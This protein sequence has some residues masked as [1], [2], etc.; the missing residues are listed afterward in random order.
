MWKFTLNGT[1]R[2]SASFDL[3]HHTRIPLV[4]GST[5]SYWTGSDPAITPAH[6]GAYLRATKLV[7]N[8]SKAVPTTARLNAF[9]Q[10]YTPN[11]LAG[12]S[13]SMGDAGTSSSLLNVT[14]IAYLASG[15]VR[16]YRASVVFG[17][18]SGSWSCHW[19]DEANL[20]DGDGHFRCSR[21]PNLSMGWGGTPTVPGGSGGA[22][23][24]IAYTHLPS[25]GYFAYL[26]T[27]RYWFFE[28]SAFWLA[29]GNMDNQDQR[30][31]YADGVMDTSAGYANRGAAW[32]IRNLGEVATFA[33]EAGN[34]RVEHPLRTE[35][36]GY[37]ANNARFYRTKYVDGGTYTEA[38]RSQSYSQVFGTSW[39]SPQGILG[40][41]SSSGGSLYATGTSGGIWM[42]AAWMQGFSVAAW[43]QLSNWAP[44]SVASANIQ[45]VRDHAYK[46][47]IARGGAQ[48]YDWRRFIVYGYPIG[49]DDTGLPPEAWDT[50]AQSYAHYLTAHALSDATLAA[51]TLKTH[52][53]DTNLSAGTPSAVFYG[54]IET[55][56]LA[57]AVEHGASG[58]A[59]AWANITGAAN[60]SAMND[61]HVDCSEYGVYPR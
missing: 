48:G 41:Y 15:D 56:G 5:F 19:R 36:L 14:G 17:L 9:Q 8:M 46:Q 38:G 61:A 25:Y 29:H 1:E 55:S 35:W 53:S 45:A 59:A 11:T 57:M 27:G 13:S 16:A 31:F 58:A 37:V 20:S 23:G 10:T 47:P 2:F 60:W 24:T 28:E 7:P 54:S 12:V 51:N 42:G 30:R 4:T 21:Y 52:G 18:S 34:G 22:N 44:S 39:V 43:G 49:T 3:K 40:E 33:P 6:D 32:A 26:L 50:P